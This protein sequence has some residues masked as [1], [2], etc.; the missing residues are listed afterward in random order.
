MTCR[1]RGR[2]S[3]FGKSAKAVRR[4]HR[5]D[6]STRLAFPG[7]TSVLPS[8]ASKRRR[9]PDEAAPGDAGMELLNYAPAARSRDPVRVH[10]QRLIEVVGT[11]RFEAEFTR[12][13][14]DTIRSEHVTAYA[15]SRNA[16]PRLLL[17]A[18]NGPLPAAKMRAVKYLAQYWKHDPASL[19][20]DAGASD[21]MA[22]RTS[23]QDID[24]SLYR[25]DCYTSLRI[26][27]R[28]T[29]MQRNGDH[30][31]RVNLY[32]SGRGGRFAQSDVDH[33]MSSAD[34]LVSLLIKNA[35]SNVSYGQKAAP[36]LFEDRLRLI[37]PNMP[38]REAEVCA[39]IMSGMTSEAIALHLGISVNTVL[40]Y[41]KRAYGRLRI[42]CQNELLRL[43][44]T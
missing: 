10:I 14:N 44:L 29:L 39:A 36:Q 13:M 3:H 20:E 28:F 33:I 15:F 2:T 9:H 4:Y 42:S 40:T 1:L 16:P 25:H 22:L 34:L 26:T 30:T 31:Y 17:A 37:E 43:I 12:A 19:V 6:R 38:T 32:R 5:P 27:D 23:P 18:S 24:D 11:P 21:A 7:E 41:R 35:A 8:Q